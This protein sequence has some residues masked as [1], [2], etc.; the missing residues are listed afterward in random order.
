MAAYPGLC[1]GVMCGDT[2]LSKAVQA[3]TRVYDGG[4][5]LLPAGYA[6]HAFVVISHD[7]G[8]TERIDAVPPHVEMLPLDGKL[9]P[10]RHALWSVNV[11]W[12]ARRKGVRE[13]RLHAAERRQYDVPELLVQA[14]PPLPGLPHP[15]GWEGLAGEDICTGL[16]YD[17][18]RALGGAPKAFATT[19]RRYSGRPETLG[20]ALRDHGEWWLSRLV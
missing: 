17:V 16:V 14:L 7:D 1:V 19:I 6:T 20:R 3:F 12:E 10:E 8:L 2:L 5:P 9:D 11:G 15:Q 13:A 18:L 4:P